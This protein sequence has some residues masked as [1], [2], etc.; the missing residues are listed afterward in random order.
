MKTAYVHL[1]RR[2]VSTME[3]RRDKQVIESAPQ[4]ALPI[5]RETLRS[6]RSGIGTA[7]AKRKSWI[8]LISNCAI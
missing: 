1:H 7:H 3:I 2:G 6:L 8:V 5:T 4:F